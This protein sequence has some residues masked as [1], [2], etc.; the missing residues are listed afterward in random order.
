[1]TS[2]LALAMSTDTR[3]TIRTLALWRVYVP[4]LDDTDPGILGYMLDTYGVCR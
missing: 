1:M 4:N 3:T 2:N